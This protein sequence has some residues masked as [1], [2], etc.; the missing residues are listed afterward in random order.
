MEGEREG[1][2][3]GGRGRSPPSG[4]TCPPHESPPGNSMAPGRLLL[5]HV[6]LSL[7]E[8]RDARGC[9]SPSFPPSCLG[10]RQKR[11][12]RWPQSLLSSGR[13]QPGMRG[14][15]TRVQWCGQEQ[16]KLEMVVRTQAAWFFLCGRWQ[17]RNALSHSLPKEPLMHFPCCQGCVSAV[18]QLN[19]STLCVRA[20]DCCLL[21]W[22]TGTRRAASSSCFFMS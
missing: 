11:R 1:G 10:R 4:C 8:G 20:F 2:R 9:M 6:H 5:P 14:T 16:A 15:F 7:E 3:K 18:G 13:T 22:E 12:E 19:G 21:V 17:W